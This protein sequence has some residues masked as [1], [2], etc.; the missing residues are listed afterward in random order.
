MCQDIILGDM[1]RGK[2]AEEFKLAVK[3]FRC[4]RAAFSSCHLKSHLFLVR[5]DFFSCNILAEDA[6]VFH[7]QNRRFEFE[8]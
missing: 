7:K 5:S 6:V 1:P 2:R 8:Q 3:H 4:A